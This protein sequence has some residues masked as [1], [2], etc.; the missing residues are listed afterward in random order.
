MAD[1]HV[2][3]RPGTDIAFLGAVVNYIYP[4]RGGYFEDYDPPRTAPTA[5]LRS[6]RTSTWTRIEA[7]GFFSGWSPEHS[8]YAIDS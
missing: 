6:S 5:R 2:P 8:A 4:P 1:L 3:I 7:S